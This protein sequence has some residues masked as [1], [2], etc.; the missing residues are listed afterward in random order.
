MA[1]SAKIAAANP[2]SNEL[3]ALALWSTIAGAVA[4]Q[5]DY[6]PQMDTDR[7]GLTA[8][9]PLSPEICVLSV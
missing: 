9:G 8:K 5:V 2:R 3:R 1:L 6:Q 7:H 4:D